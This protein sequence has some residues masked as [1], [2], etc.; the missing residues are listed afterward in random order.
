M[1]AAV[2]PLIYV[3]AFLAVVLL[4]Q[5]ASSALFSF[6]DRS[7]RINRR[8]SML[9]TGMSQD[10]VYAAL[11]RT[12]EPLH[13][14]SPALAEL[15]DRA[16]VWLRQAGL[17]IA[18][19]R[20]FAIVAGATAALFLIGLVVISAFAGRI[21]SVAALAILIAA[22][23]LP[24]VSAWLYI[25]RSRNK[26]LAALTE[27]LPLALDVINRAVRAGHPVI[28]AIK[29][30]A[31]EM[32]DPI[33][34]EFGLIV[35]ET[36]YGVDIKDALANFAARTG[37]RDAHFFAVSVGVQFE[38]GGNLVEILSGL[39]KVIRARITLAKRVRALASEGRASAYILS[40]LPPLL[41]GFLMVI[42]P[43]YY[44]SKFADPIFWPVVAA[45]SVV[46]LIGWAM[47]DR[48]INFKY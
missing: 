4:A 19:M 15:H 24:S 11:V 5:A 44:T 48:I 8:L 23:A 36:S 35:D 10:D 45:V 30:A 29:L 20:L 46:Y 2:S 39:A 40:A 32:G 42:H 17:S 18:P 47:I 13:R 37:S 33:G 7:R 6:R 41:V 26:R 1:S 28:S 22:C 21:S 25:N 9:D 27:Q 3:F 14:F 34:T 16:W 43:S 12:P 38:T 31:S